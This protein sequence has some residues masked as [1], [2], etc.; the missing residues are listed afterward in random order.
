[1]SYYLVRQLKLIN[2]FNNLK[3]T[4]PYLSDVFKR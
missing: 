1:M 2:I 3:Y 4:P